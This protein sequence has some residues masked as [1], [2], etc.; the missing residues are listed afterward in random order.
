[1][2]LFRFLLLALLFYL[3]SKIFAQLFRS[4]PEQPGTKVSGTSQTN[5]LDL[6]EEDVEDVDY[7][8]LPRK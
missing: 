7:R 2:F 6:T 8:E 3:V 5:P 4:T 1:M